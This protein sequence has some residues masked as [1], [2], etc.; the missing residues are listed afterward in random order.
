MKHGQKQ[1]GVTLVQK[2]NNNYKHDQEIKLLL[3]GL[4]KGNRLQRSY[5]KYVQTT[6]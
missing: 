1:N 6:K 2:N 4:D 5:Y 3:G